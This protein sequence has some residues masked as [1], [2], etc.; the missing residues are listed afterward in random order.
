MR[1]IVRIDEV[2]SAFADAKRGPFSGCTNLYAAPEKL[3]EWIVRSELFGERLGPATLFFR[4][5]RDFWHLYFCA[6]DEESV[7]TSLASSEVVKW[8]PVVLDIVGQERDVIRK[9]ALFDSAGFRP[10]E[11]LFRMARIATFG[12]PGEALANAKGGGTE[13]AGRADAPLIRDLLESCFD[14]HA[15]QL[16]TLYEIEA[17]LDAGSVLVTRG[18]SGLAGL[19]HFETRTM[20]SILRYWLVTPSYRGRGVGSRLMRRYFDLHPNIHRFLLWVLAHN[21]DVIA[22]YTGYGFAQDGLIDVVLANKLIRQ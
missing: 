12:A 1:A 9:V 14:R 22:Q 10:Y 4:R 8:E 20:T 13:I 17:A 19:I 5:D 21:S 18:A 16:P 7:A 6:P 11:R 3:R 2:G 15:E